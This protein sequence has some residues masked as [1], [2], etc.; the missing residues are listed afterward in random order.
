MPFHL[1]DGKTLAAF[2]HNRHH[3]LNYTTLDG[4]KVEMMKDRQ[5]IWV[6]RTSTCSSTTGYATF[7]FH[8]AGAG[9]FTCKLRK[10]TCSSCREE[11]S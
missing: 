3:D 2:H 7:S 8:T 6:A 10:K 9:S 11:M 5:E 1:S 4:G